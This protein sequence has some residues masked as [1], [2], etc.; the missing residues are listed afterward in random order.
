MNAGVVR[1]L[2]QA[3]IVPSRE[4][5]TLRGQ[6]VSHPQVLPIISMDVTLQNKL[7]AEI[8]VCLD[9]SCCRL[10]RGSFPSDTSLLDV[11]FM[12]GNPQ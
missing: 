11:G 6:V 1:E 10:A 9:D 2:L 5:A 8:A 7:P 4:C 3:L 12:D